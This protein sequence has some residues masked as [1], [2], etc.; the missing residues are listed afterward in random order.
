MSRD[1]I[2]MHGI[3]HILDS[4]MGEPVLSEEETDLSSG[5]CEMW[6]DYILR[7]LEG[8]D[9]KRYERQDDGEELLQIAMGVTAENFV[10]TTCTLARE[11]FGIMKANI[12]I[13]TADAACVLF[14]HEN[15]PYFALLK[16]NYREAYTHITQN[17]CNRLVRQRILPPAGQR[18][19]EAFAANLA[20][21]EVLVAERRYPV[22]GQMRN[23][24]SELYLGLP[25]KMSPKG[26]LQAVIRAVE[27]VDRKYYGDDNPERKV[28]VKELIWQELEEKSRM[29]VNAIKK[30]VFAGSP[31]M[32]A[33]LEEK[34]HRY[35]LNNAIL[36]G[37]KDTIKKL[38]QQRLVTDRGIEVIFPTAAGE[39]VKIEW[40]ED[41]G[42]VLIGN[43]Q[44]LDAR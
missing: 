5:I 7:L 18:L 10:Q 13:P 23:Y 16:L 38:D 25:P 39:E 15:D 8:E 9:T 32:Q 43:L 34:L 44:R 41:G 21:G 31:G 3:L 30:K 20:T 4:M 2:L 36:P 40:G 37:G 6:K 27:Q 14:R 22:N 29:D 28:R 11:L 17:G 19:A 1:I 33:D 12:D 35:E 26:Q 24:L 42:S